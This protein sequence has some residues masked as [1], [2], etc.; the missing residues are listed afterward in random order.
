MKSKKQI[1]TK[2]EVFSYGL[3]FFAGGGFMSVICIVFIITIP[4]L[5]LTIPI[6]I[7]GIIMMII[8]PFLPTRT[9][10]CPKCHTKQKI[11]KNKKTYECKECHDRVV[12]QQ[13]V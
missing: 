10:E 2:G 13:F 9:E 4:G 5:I 1:E 6:T 3:A 7:I 11:L 8:A 12:P